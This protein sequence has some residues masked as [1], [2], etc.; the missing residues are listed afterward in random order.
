MVQKLIRSVVAV[1]RD[2][3]VILPSGIV[4][5]RCRSSFGEHFPNASG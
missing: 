5:S 3:S 2:R 4:V 1:L